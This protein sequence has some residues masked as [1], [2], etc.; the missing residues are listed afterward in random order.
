MEADREKLVKYDN[1]TYCSQR[2]VDW[3]IDRDRRRSFQAN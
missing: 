1:Q 2:C 3:K